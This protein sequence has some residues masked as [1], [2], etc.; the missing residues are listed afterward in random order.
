MEQFRALSRLPQRIYANLSSRAINVV[1]RAHEATGSNSHPLVQAAKRVFID[2]QAH[3]STIVVDNHDRL[4]QLQSVG[5]TE[6]HISAI[7]LAHLFLDYALPP[8]LIAAA[9]PIIHS[10]TGLPAAADATTAFFAARAAYGV[11]TGLAR[12][13][14]YAVIQ[15]RSATN[16]G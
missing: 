9:Y 7:V 11:T 2:T 14:T 6:S 12:E 5:L 8:F 1:L 10:L 4:A 15:N 3:S 13:V 16:S